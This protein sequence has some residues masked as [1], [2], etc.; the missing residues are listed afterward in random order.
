[1][2]G[3][4]TRGFTMR[5]A[6]LTSR[7]AGPVV[8]LGLALVVAGCTG[9]SSSPTPTASP[10]GSPAASPSLSPAATVGGSLTVYSGRSEKLVGPIIER[11]EKASGVN[12]E[13]R[14]GDT[15]E[16]AA[17]ILEEGDNSPADVFFGQDA[18]ALGA[19]AKENRSAPLPRELLDRVD[20]RFRSPDGDWV[21]IS[22]RARVAA[23]N[24]TRLK[25]ED[26]P[27]SILE[28]TDP[29]WKG[30]LGW[31]PTNGSFQSFV[32][33]LRVLKGEEAARAWLE[34]IQANEP[35]VYEKNTQALEA[36]AAGEVDVAFINHYYLLAAIREQGPDFP[37]ANHF[38]QGGDPGAL[39]NVAGVSILRTARNPDAAHAFADFLL[40]DEGQ[41]YFASETFEYPLVP[42][43]PVDERLVPLA[44]VESPQIDL[45]DLSDL[46]GTLELLQKAGII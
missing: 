42:G 6:L 22:G 27:A 17:T 41:K 38:F 2:V 24:T 31:V 35:K 7:S 16:L 28:L 8:A 11:F 45:S 34:G 46:R 32:T 9:G 14:Y 4:P 20:P 12:V 40:S 33:A 43:V 39:V 30:R 44:E 1:M 15:A 13:V 5:L 23:Y 26:L 18:G 37:V 10:E 36:V 29:K 19:L 3:V 25:P 21:G